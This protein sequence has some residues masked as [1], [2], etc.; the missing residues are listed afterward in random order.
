MA[1]ANHT[2]Y[3]CFEDLRGA[4]I[5]AL[6]RQI[7]C[8][9]APRILYVQGEPGIGKSMCMEA[10]RKKID[11]ENEHAHGDARINMLH[12]DFDSD[13]NGDASLSCVMDADT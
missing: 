10:L 5:D 6:L 4:E 11:F 3:A 7:R 13:T 8:S 12:F 1:G 2:V 9:P